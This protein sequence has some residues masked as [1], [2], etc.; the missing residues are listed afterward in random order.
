MYG[1]LPFHRSRTRRIDTTTLRNVR[2]PNGVDYWL[3]ARYPVVNAND[4]LPENARLK[5]V[6]E[7]LTLGRTWDRTILKKF[8]LAAFATKSVELI[9]T[10]TPAVD[11]AL[12]GT[13]RF[14][15]R[16]GAQQ[17]ILT[18]SEDDLK[19]WMEVKVASIKPS[20]RP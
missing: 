8:P 17:F 4:P 5:F 1:P 9:I 7:D 18:Y 13:I 12:H 2:V 15:I 3:L 6:I 14:T 16:Y 20:C 11:S 19:G 10:G